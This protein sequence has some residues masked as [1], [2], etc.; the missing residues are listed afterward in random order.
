MH[1]HGAGTFRRTYG[2]DKVHEL[3]TLL[4]SEIGS[5]RSAIPR[6]EKSRILYR[7]MPGRLTDHSILLRD[8]SWD[9]TIAQH[10]GLQGSRHLF[11]DIGP[12]VGNQ[13][14]PAQSALEI[15]RMNPG[16]GTICVDLPESVE[17]FNSFQDTEAKVRVEA[18]ANLRISPADARSSLRQ[19][20][21]PLT[22]DSSLPFNRG[23]DAAAIIIRAAN[24]VDIYCTEEENTQ[25]V[26][27][28]SEDFRDDQVLLLFNRLILR[29][30]RGVEVW[31]LVGQSSRRGFNHRTRGIEAYGPNNTAPYT[32]YPEENC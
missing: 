8:A 31:Q 2:S 12:A 6:H 19:S 22:S 5:Y 17:I 3:W 15:A 4:G 24:S 20:I 27:Q 13:L 26:Q 1:E 9:P 10:L 18:T 7:T 29:K 32:L 21:E 11:V 16:M 28:I 14:C 23:H 30:D 25:I